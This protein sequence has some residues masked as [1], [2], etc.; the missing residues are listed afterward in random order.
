MLHQL[1]DIT[2]YAT[3]AAVEELFLQADRKAV[4]TTANWARAASVELATELDA[5]LCDLI[6]DR[7]RAGL[8]NKMG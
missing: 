1:Y 5:A 4:G 3:A 7:D 6:L 8:L 2:A